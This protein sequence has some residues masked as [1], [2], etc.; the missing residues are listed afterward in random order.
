MKASELVL[1]YVHLLCYKCHK[2]NLNRR[3]SY[4]DSPDPIKNKKAAIN[5][6]I[7]GNNINTFNM[8]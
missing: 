3:G 5:S 7:K 6:I 8:L 4:V 2:V 1:D